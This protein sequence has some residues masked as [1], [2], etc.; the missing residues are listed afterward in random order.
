MHVMM[1]QIMALFDEYQSKE[2]AK[3]IRTGK[4][5]RYRYYACSMK[6]RQWPTGLHRHGGANGQA[7]QFGRQPP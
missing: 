6:E 1:R 2:N 5:G 3:T 7:G 4:G